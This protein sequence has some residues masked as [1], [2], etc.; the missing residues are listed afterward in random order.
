M[1]ECIKSS[2]DEPYAGMIKASHLVV[3]TTCLHK[4]GRCQIWRV[5]LSHHQTGYAKIA[6][7]TTATYSSPI[8]VWYSIEDYAYQ[9]MHV[10]MVWTGRT[11]FGVWRALQFCGA[12]PAGV[13]GAV[14][15]HG[16]VLSRCL[17]RIQGQLTCKTKVVHKAIYSLQR[18]F[19]IQSWL[20]TT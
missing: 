15:L 2:A 9:G 5:M 10:A 17:F 16:T 18:V 7:S 11:S 19:S 20:K 3:D 14:S 4:V 1:K 12:I 8:N 13:A 6:I